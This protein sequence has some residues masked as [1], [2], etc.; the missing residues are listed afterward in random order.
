MALS[1]RQDNNLI[2]LLARTTSRHLVESSI[3]ALHTDG[4]GTQIS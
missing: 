4:S 1:V 2:I 3:I